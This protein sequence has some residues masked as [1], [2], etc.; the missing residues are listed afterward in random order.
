MPPPAKSTALAGFKPAGALIP[1][2]RGQSGSTG[3]AFIWVAHKQS[4]L[5]DEMSGKVQNLRSANLVYVS[6]DITE[7]LNPLKCHVLEAF[8]YYAELDAGGEIVKAYAET[9]ESRPKNAAEFVEAVLLVYTSKGV[10]PARVTFKK[11]MCRGIQPMLDELADITK[12]PDAWAARSKDHARA[13]KDISADLANFRF[14]AELT[15]SSK[16]TKDGR[17]EYPVANAKV[18][19]TTPNEVA[20]LATLDAKLVEA[21]RQAIRNRISDVKS[22]M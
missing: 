15:T 22:K 10:R 1:E 7:H 12:E 20:A 11:A 14:F 5:W 9:T 21:V 6:A 2:T 16:P 4:N 18:S 17:F 19:P 3:D 13:A 8:R